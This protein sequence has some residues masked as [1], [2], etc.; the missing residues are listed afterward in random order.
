MNY[1]AM[2]GRIIYKASSLAAAVRKYLWDDRKERQQAGL[3]QEL[4]FGERLFIEVE[5]VSEAEWLEAG[6]GDL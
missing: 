3:P 4:R 6:G 2:D 1:Y 5:R